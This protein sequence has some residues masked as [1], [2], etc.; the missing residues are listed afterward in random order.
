M[1]ERVCVGERMWMGESVCGRVRE[2]VWESERERQCV[3]E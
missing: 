3:G 2:S 1:L